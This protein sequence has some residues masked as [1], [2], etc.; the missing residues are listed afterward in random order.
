MMLAALES[1]FPKSPARKQ[2]APQAPSPPPSTSPQYYLKMPP[3][4]GK[5]EQEKKVEK[6]VEKEGAFGS[7]LVHLLL[8][9]SFVSGC[10]QSLHYLACS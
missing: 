1:S 9:G 3:K 5:K 7:R 10:S 8:V 6:K 4:G 2:A